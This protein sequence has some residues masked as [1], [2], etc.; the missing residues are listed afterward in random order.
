[1]SNFWSGYIIALTTVFLI[2][3][4]WLLFA[5]RKGQKADQTDQ[6]TGHSFDGIEE[7][8]NPLP[9]W[10]FMLFIATIVFSVVYLVLYPGMGKWKGLLG[11]TQ[12]EQYQDEVVRAE[13]QFAPIFARYVD[14]P[15][16][17]VA[18]DEDAV[19]IGQRLFATNCSVCHGSDARG[20]FGFPNLADNDWI[21]GGS[22]D[23]IK[24]T[25]REGRQAAMPAW[26]AVIGEAGVRNTAGYVRSLAGLETENVD[27]E[28]G[29]KV[30]QTNCVACHGPEGKGNPMLGAPNLTDDIWLYGSSMLQVQHTLRYGRN[31]N[32]PAQAHLGEDKIHMLAS[33]VYSL[34]QED[35]EVTDTGRPKG[36]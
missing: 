21:W 11:W 36:R 13:E 6:T 9:R 19:R 1:M 15:V 35:G 7:Y 17:D 2:L 32:M 3:I 33:Y 10:W 25:L 29:Q 24:T 22:V 30:F 8:D 31:G 14:M 26:L 34:S 27:L 18:R 12:I 16:E 20:A 4:T 28:A 23:Q 5:T